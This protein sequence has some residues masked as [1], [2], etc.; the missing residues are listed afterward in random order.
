MN[1][2]RHKDIPAIGI[3]KNCNKGVCH[4]CCEDVENGLACKDTCTRLVNEINEVISRNKQVY[5]I[6]SKSRLPA[7]GVLMYAFFAVIFGVW[8][9]SIWRT[10]GDVGIFP[11]GFA[12]AFAVI[13]IIAYIRNRKIG[14]RC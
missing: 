10:R 7:T 13:G 3:C 11:F 1:C 6:G 4:D 9:I 14:I 8:G 12:I 2:Y 5:G